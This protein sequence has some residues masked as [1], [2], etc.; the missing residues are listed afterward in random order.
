VGGEH[1]QPGLGFHGKRCCS[2]WRAYQAR[3]RSRIVEHSLC[4][5]PSRQE[6]PCIQSIASRRRFR[7]HRTGYDLYLRKREAAEAH[8][9]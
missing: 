5:A 8:I 9:S 3:G 4:S 2:N 1:R 7:N 6:R